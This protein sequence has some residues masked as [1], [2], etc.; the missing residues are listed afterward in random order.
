MKEK[1]MTDELLEIINKK[2]DKYRDWKSTISTAEYNIKKVNFNTFDDIVNQNIDEAK[3]KY[4]HDVFLAQQYDMK[5]TWAT[6]NETLN[7]SKNKT[8]FP[9]EFIIDGKTL[10]DP[11]NIADS[12]N[13]FFANIG[14]KFHQALNLMMRMVYS[15]TI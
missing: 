6:I 7:R 13:Q 5:K 4:Y 9:E 10:T 2:N 8:N 15:L 12:F 11:Q 3:R 1:W 14:T